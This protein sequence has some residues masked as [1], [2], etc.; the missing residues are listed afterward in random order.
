M[1]GVRALHTA[2][3]LLLLAVSTARAQVATRAQP[4]DPVPSAGSL[5]YLDLVREVVPDMETNGRRFTGTRTIDLP[6]AGGYEMRPP[7]KPNL[8]RG[9][10]IVALGGTRHLL[11]IDLGEAY[12]DAA[13][14]AILA[15]FDTSSSPRLLS[16]LSV[17]FDRSNF[18]LTPAVRSLGAGQLIATASEHFNSSQTYRSTVLVLLRDGKLEPIDTISTFGDRRC[19]FKRPQQLTIAT[20]R[21]KTEFADV[22]AAVTEYVIPTGSDCGTEKP[23]EASSRTITVVYRWDEAQ[24]KYVPDSDAFDKLAADNSQRF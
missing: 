10:K 12:G 16:A 4:G 18:F 13:N 3:L 21:S 5:T 23:P 24:A 9:I 8:D 1:N 20:N 15:L 14:Y 7:V 19:S 22:V 11:L 6:H 17:G 2:I